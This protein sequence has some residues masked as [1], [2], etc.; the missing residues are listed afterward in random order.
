MGGQNDN[1]GGILSSGVGAA[2]V[3]TLS[4]G[5]WVQQSKLIGPQ[6]IGPAGQGYSVALS[7]DGTVA[8][9]GAPNDNSEAGAAW[10]YTLSK[11]VPTQPG[12]KLPLGT[13][14][15]GT[16]NQGASVALSANGRTAIVG[17]SSDNYNAGAAWVYTFSDRA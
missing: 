16:A 4:D 11:G 10:V 6:A 12:I 13:D 7:S 17:G 3:Y 1:G 9:V 14:A 5:V 8:I 2:W 15:I